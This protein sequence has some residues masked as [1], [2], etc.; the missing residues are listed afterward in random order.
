MKRIPFRRSTYLVQA[1]NCTARFVLFPAPGGKRSRFSHQAGEPAPL[2][3]PILPVHQQQ[4]LSVQN[5]LVAINY[6]KRTLAAPARY[7]ACTILVFPMSI[8]L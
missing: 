2:P 5:T 1:A 3:H 6:L 8:L 4:G 7:A